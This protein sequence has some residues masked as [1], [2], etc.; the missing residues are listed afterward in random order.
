MTTAEER[1][2]DPD[3]RV[4]DLSDKLDRV[5]RDLLSA[6][7]GLERELHS[8][9][10]DLDRD[11]RNEESDREREDTALGDRIDQVEREL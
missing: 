11:I 8:V 3:N 4:D 5:E 7:D 6:V 2:Q 1:I 9:R 10:D